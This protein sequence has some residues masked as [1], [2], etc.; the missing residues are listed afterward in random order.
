MPKDG[1]RRAP[2]ETRK[3]TVRREHEVR[4]QRILYLALGAVAL[5]VLIVLGIG[6]F[7]EN[8]A[9][10]NNPIATV[11]GNAITIREYQA[12]VRYVASSLF[13]QLQEVNANLAQVNADPT[14]SFFKESLEQQQQQILLQLLE[15]PRNEMES[16]IEDELVRQ[17]AARRNLT[18]SA[19]EIDEELERFIG[20]ARATPTP[21]AGPS[22][23]PTLTATP[24]KT[25]TITPTFTPSPT[26]TITV[27]PAPPTETPTV[28]PTETPFPTSTPMTYQGYLDEKKKYFDALSKNVQVSEADIRKLVE[29]GLLRRKLQKAIGDEIP[30]SEE[31]IQARHILVKTLEDALKVK[32][33]LDK[34]EDF[35]KLAAEF[36]EDTGSK[37]EGGDLGWFPR[38]QM[39]K[40]FEDAAFA[41]K[42][43]EISQPISTTFGA[44]LIQVLAREANRP[45]DPVVLQQK[46]STAFNDWLTK[47]VLNTD[48]K[49]ERFYKDEYVPPEVKRQI[50][51]L[52]AGLR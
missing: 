9:K 43:N 51:L 24:S 22:P 17:E 2:Q 34:G 30:T 48:N 41:L 26:P 44:H 28:G 52:Q 4:Q 37:A 50:D 12:R 5:I 39:V 13:S 49:I 10:L 35:A 38:G 15:L 47:L 11:N 32:E 42:V 40:E 23:T 45:L 29:V 7:Q 18:V 1:K 36:S 33:R 6:Y 25:P 46:Q 20:Y 27:T 3:Q 8:I 19:D 31:Q 21:T 16:M 14:L